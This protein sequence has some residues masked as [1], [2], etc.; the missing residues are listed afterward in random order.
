MKILP[1]KFLHAA[2]QLAFLAWVTALLLPSAASEPASATGEVSPARVSEI[3]AWLPDKPI[4][5]GRPI[6]DRTYWSSPEVLAHASKYVQEAEKL[7]NKE[8]PAWDDKAYIDYS[9]TGSRV[10]SSKMQ[11]SRASWLKPLVLAE[12]VENKGR[13]LPLINK[14]FESYASEP[15]WIYAFHD[16][17]LKNFH[18]EEIDVDL[19]SSTFGHEVAEALYLLGDKID[20]GVRKHMEAA[21]QKRIFEPFRRTVATGK[22]GCYWLGNE[23]HPIQNNWNCVCLAGVVG[24]AQAILPDKDERAFFVAAGEHYT[25]YYLNSIPLDGYCGEGVGYWGYGFGH[26]AMLREEIVEA[27]GGRLDLF[28]NPRIVDNALYGVRILIGPSAIPPFADCHFG[29]K[30]SPELVAYCNTVMK[31]GLNAPSFEAI[32]KGDLSET[33]MNATPCAKPQAGSK[34]EDPLRFYFDKAGVLACRPAPGSACSLGI[35]IKAGGNGSHSHNDIGSYEIAIGDVEP[36]GDPGGPEYDSST[37]SAQR[38]DHKILNSYGHPVPIIAGKI[39]ILAADA[40]PTV[41][42][43]SFTPDRDELTMD[44]TSAYDV[45]ALQKLTRKMV[46]SRAGS[47]E[48]SIIDEA[49]FREPTTFEDALITHGDWKQID[50]KTI[51]ITLGQAKLLVSIDASDAFHLKPE[52]IDDQHIVFTRIGLVFDKPIT[53][54]KI[55]MTFKPQAG[56]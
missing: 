3:A 11:G 51:Q 7:L 4:G 42:S 30:P 20:P 15:T 33:L 52:T 32:K 14:A 21:L 34:Q 9:V 53:T 8:F 1:G 49:S 36:T 55:S 6:D 45:P 56:P 46:Y 2:T 39:Q 37:F 25:Q 54:A 47:G 35:G 24:A 27:T 44:I 18:G 48:I 17:G 23:K 13:F 10:R 29:T 31:L 40:K 12:C 50:P 19:R 22:G 16:K 43:T 26:L 5:F 38:Y 41:G 28:S